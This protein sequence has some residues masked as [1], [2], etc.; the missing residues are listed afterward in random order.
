MDK[1]V[2]PVI[3][4]AKFGNLEGL[5]LSLSEVKRVGGSR[6]H[7]TFVMCGKVLL[8]SKLLSE[9]TRM[10]YFLVF[11]VFQEHSMLVKFNTVKEKI[12][13]N[14]NGQRMME[15]GSWRTVSQRKWMLTPII[16]EMRKGPWFCSVDLLEQGGSRVMSGRLSRCCGHIPPVD[17]YP[18]QELLPKKLSEVKPALP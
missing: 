10:R 1:I 9:Y 13:L 2:K 18:H 16:P 14:Q 7:T 5:H 12:F 3:Y 4:E 8:C 15:E 6:D 17:V 11:T